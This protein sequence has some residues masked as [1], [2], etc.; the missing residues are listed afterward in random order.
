MGLGER[1]KS[2]L[3]RTV[4]PAPVAVVRAEPT[5]MFSAHDDPVRPSERLLD[6][7]L[8]AVA[9]ART[10]DVA[11]LSA[12]LSEPPDYP[13][14]W[15]GEHYKLLAGLVATLAPRSVVE[16]GTGSGL[17]ALAMLL[18]LPADSRLVTF[19][20]LAWRDDP[21]TVLRAEDFADGR[22]RQELDDVS[23]PAG[24]ARHRE[25]L[26]SADFLFIDAPKDGAMEYRLLAQLETLA[27]AQPIV[28]F[29]DIRFVTMLKL[30][31][32]LKRPKLDLTSFGHWSGTGL[33]EWV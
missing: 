7:A 14:V 19:D 28:M 29:D 25:L 18:T 13:N 16:I 24:L 17:S 22:L 3:L 5:L 30:W 10:V 12:R 32:E 21:Q 2:K 20:L 31:R 1:L 6:V 15:P 8:G 11:P 4:L 23:G 26:E 9:A 27:L 33:V